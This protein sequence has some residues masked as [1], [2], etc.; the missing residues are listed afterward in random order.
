MPST[1]AVPNSTLPLEMEQFAAE[2]YGCTVQVVGL[3]PRR[4]SQVRGM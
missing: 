1:Q 4:S 3:N 2:K